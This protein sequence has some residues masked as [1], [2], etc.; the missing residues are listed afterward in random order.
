MDWSRRFNRSGVFA[1]F[2]ATYRD[3]VTTG[4][5]FILGTV[6]L[7]GVASSFLAVW[8][9][10]ILIAFGL[11]VLVVWPGPPPTQDQRAEAALEALRG[12][13]RDY[14]VSK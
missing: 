1:R 6:L 3:G 5:R 4:P 8:V 7:G 9:A 10:G 14:P 12:L 2:T 11:V 13:A